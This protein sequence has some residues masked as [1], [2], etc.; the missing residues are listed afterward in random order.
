MEVVGSALSSESG[1]GGKGPCGSQLLNWSS[2][3]DYAGL[4]YQDIGWWESSAYT[5]C[6]HQTPPDMLHKV[7][8]T[9]ASNLS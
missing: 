8:E 5:K 9:L 2:S 1:A 3:A 7:A 6:I 4:A